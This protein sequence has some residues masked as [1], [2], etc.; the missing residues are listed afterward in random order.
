MKPVQ[1]YIVGLVLG[2]A[3]FGMYANNTDDGTNGAIKFGLGI[4]SL[5]FI[6]QGTHASDAY[7]SPANIKQRR[8]IK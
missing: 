4:A 3:C 6:V 7:D 2:A 5:A 1:L 8:S